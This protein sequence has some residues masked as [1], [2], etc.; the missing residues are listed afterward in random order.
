MGRKAVEDTNNETDCSEK[1]TCNLKQ[2][3]KN[4]NFA[5]R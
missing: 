2:Q 3:H 4:G 5:V 1:K